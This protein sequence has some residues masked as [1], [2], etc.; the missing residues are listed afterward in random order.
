MLVFE[1][2][3]ICAHL[4]TAVSTANENDTANVQNPNNVLSTK[5]TLFQRVH[6]VH[7]LKAEIKTSVGGKYIHFKGFNASKL[8]A[9]SDDQIEEHVKKTGENCH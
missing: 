2:R 4:I 8:A 1:F 3:Y 5:E 9:L 7:C 6:I